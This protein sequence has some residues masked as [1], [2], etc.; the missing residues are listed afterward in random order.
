MYKVAF[1]DI[2]GTLVSFKTHEVPEST[3]R[4]IDQL[5]AQG[6]KVVICTGRGLNETPD[7]LRTGFDAYVTLSGQHCFDDAGVY[8]SAPIAETDVCTIYDQVQSGLYDA[9]C[10]QADGSFAN[11]KT[12]KI[13]EIEERVNLHYP[14]AED[15]GKTL[16]APVYQ[17]CAFVEAEDEHLITDACASVTTTRWTHLF[18]DVVPADGGKDKGVEA[19]LARFGA[20]R[21]EAICFGD[22]EN[23]LPMFSACGTAVAM[24]NAW[25]SV[26]AA[27]DYVTVD[28]DSD[29]IFSACRHFGLV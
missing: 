14:L 5:R 19:T 21:D 4:A 20:T 29:G 28:V 3:W 2:D 13:R 9:I 27:A 7:F 11:K 17:F 1:F 15:F 22:G 26:K 12:P 18:C 8:R 24:G 23:D 16:R 25:D 10:T 6:I